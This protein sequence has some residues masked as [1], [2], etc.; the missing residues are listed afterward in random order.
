MVIFKCEILPEIRR[1][2][3][4]G[5]ENGNWRE[6]EG[7]EEADAGDDNETECGGEIVGRGKKARK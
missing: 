2:E 3:E 4:D 5:G 1:V 7:R 6:G